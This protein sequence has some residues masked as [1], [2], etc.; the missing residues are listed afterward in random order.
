M[1]AARRAGGATR[2]AV[3]FSCLARGPNLFGPGSRELAQLRR[4]LGDV[5]L[6]GMFCDGEICNARLYGYTGVLGLFA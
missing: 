5:P 3:Y 4:E 2:A 6:I 1:D